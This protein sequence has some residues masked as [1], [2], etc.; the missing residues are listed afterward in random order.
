[1]LS[2]FAT[3][4]LPGNTI[5]DP[6]QSQCLRVLSLGQCLSSGPSADPK[7]PQKRSQSMPNQLLIISIIPESSLFY[8]QDGPMRSTMDRESLLSLEN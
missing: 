6:I 1:M 5:P 4:S 7:G 2:C 8:G 3:K